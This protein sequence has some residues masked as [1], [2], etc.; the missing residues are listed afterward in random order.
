MEVPLVHGDPPTHLVGDIAPGG[1]AVA[2]RGA[3]GGRRKAEPPEGALARPQRP[4]ARALRAAVRRPAG[5]E[6]GYGGSFLDGESQMAIDFPVARVR[7][8]DKRAVLHFLPVHLPFYETDPTVDPTA[9][10]DRPRDVLGE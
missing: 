4:V 2:D 5:Q 6:R 7:V 8:E 3:A 1:R 10:D 9:G